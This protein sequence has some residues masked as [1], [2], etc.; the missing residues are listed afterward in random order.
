MIG[1]VLC[2]NA[3]VSE[4]SSDSLIIA[5]HLSELTA[6]LRLASPFFVTVIHPFGTYFGPLLLTGSAN[7]RIARLR[8]RAE[9]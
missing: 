5:D 8:R 9:V 1:P 7:P 6:A 3:F 2:P 4:V